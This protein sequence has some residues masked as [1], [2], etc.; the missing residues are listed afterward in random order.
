[1]KPFRTTVAV[2]AAM[3]VLPASALAV[4]ADLRHSSSLGVAPQTATQDLRTP[5]SRGTVPAGLR[6]LGTDV[7]APDQQSPVHRT[8]PT[9]VTVPSA[10]GFDWGAAV[11]GAAVAMGAIALLAGG[12]GIRRRHSMAIG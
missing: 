12:V 5:D 6:P 8:S 3:L 1:M 10:S 2:A 4:P 7:A 9:G 11:I